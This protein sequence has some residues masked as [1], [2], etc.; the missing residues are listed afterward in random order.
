MRCERAPIPH[1][2]NRVASVCCCVTLLRV[3]FYL[4]HFSFLKLTP[5]DSGSGGGF[6][7]KLENSKPFTNL[8]GCLLHL[9]MPRS[10][11][12]PGFALDC[13][14][15]LWLCVCTAWVLFYAILQCVSGVG[16]A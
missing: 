1:S 16:E 7:S 2:A 12:R 14:G 13:V 3:C 9:C 8:G 5:V 15:L 10:L 11:T 4:P 6:L